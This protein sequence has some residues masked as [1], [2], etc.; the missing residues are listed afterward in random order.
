MVG[1]REGCLCD[2]IPERS[3]STIF[4]QATRYGLL[5]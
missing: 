1:I 4:G 2:V 3:G 5:Q